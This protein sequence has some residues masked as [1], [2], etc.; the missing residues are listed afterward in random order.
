[1]QKIL[2]AEQS[3]NLVLVEERITELLQKEPIHKE[4][5]QRLIAL[6]IRQGNITET[7]TLLE[8]YIELYMETQA[9]VQLSEFLCTQ[10]RYNDAFEYMQQVLMMEPTNFYM[11]QY[12]GEIALQMNSLDQARK[13]FLTACKLSEYKYVRALKSAIYVLGSAKENRTKSEKILKHF[14]ELLEDI[15]ENLEEE[16][17]KL[18]Q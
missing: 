11:W 8:K 10:G 2:E 3:G 5:I 17:E 6:R 12:C 1:M 18:L 15:E 13:L 7:I 4:A 9:Y 16:K 14:E